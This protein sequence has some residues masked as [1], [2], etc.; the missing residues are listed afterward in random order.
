MTTRREFVQGLI[1]SV[2]GASALSACGDAPSVVA[3]AAG[4]GG[5]FYSSEEMALVSRISELIIPR[6]ETPGALEA[7]VPGYL[8]G[9]MNEWASAETQN[10]HREALKL[11]SIRLDAKSGDFLTA[12][13]TEAI[14]ALDALD[15]EAFEGDNSL[16]GYRS[17]KGYITQS[18][19]AS[20]VGATEELMWVAVPGVWDPSVEITAGD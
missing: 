19:F 2:G 13:E 3:T 4:K 8:D 5:Q 20:E 11:I 7:N 10:Y 12:S 1:I 17:L 14:A 15:R 18:Y 16:S 6:T 9:L